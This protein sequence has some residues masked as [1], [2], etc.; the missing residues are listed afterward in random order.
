MH[1]KVA[2]GRVPHADGE[3]GKKYKKQKRETW[4]KNTKI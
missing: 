2:P 1:T 4:R 3:R